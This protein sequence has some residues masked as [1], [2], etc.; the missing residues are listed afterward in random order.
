MTEAKD[1]KNEIM[2]VGDE[3]IGKVSIHEELD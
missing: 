3:L 1:F 2:P